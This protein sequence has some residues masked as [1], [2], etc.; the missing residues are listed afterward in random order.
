MSDEA[1]RLPAR[2]GD[3]ELDVR[4]TGPTLDVA[5]SEMATALARIDEALKTLQD[6]EGVLATHRVRAVLNPNEPVFTRQ[7]GSPTRA[8][9][10]VGVL[11]LLGWGAALLAVER[12]RRPAYDALPERAAALASV[13]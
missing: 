2:S 10:V 11:G 5:Q 6:R 3:P 13:R 9:G 7:T 4:S 1:C 8:M 12:V